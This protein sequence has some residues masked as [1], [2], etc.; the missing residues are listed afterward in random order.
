[1]QPSFEGAMLPDDRLIAQAGST[2]LAAFR[3]TVAD[4]ST[5][6][7]QRRIPNDGLEREQSSLNEIEGG[8]C[9]TCAPRDQENL[10]RS[11]FSSA[12]G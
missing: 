4:L 8:V 1:M 3:H 7:A 6:R 2:A 9:T 5:A 10:T 12:S 11:N